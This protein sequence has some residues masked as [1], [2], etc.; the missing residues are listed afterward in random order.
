M[1]SPKDLQRRLGG[2]LFCL[3]LILFFGS[4]F[5]QEPDPAEPEQELK[6]L[7]REAKANPS[8]ADPEIL[9]EIYLD[10][11]RHWPRQSDGEEAVRKV[12]EGGE[13][14]IPHLMRLLD[15]RDYRLKPAVA[16]ILSRFTLSDEDRETARA[17]IEPLLFH[18]K[19]KACYRHLLQ[20][21]HAI[22]R[23]HAE[24]LSV[25][26]LDSTD[27]AL[28]QAAFAVL[29]ESTSAA[30][31]DALRTLLVVAEGDTR[32][33]AFQLM[34][35]NPD[36]CVDGA[37]LA[38]VGDEHAALAADVT[39]YL[40]HRNNEQVKGELKTMLSYEPDRVFA[41]AVAAMVSL[42]NNYNTV[43]LTEEQIPSLERFLNARDPLLRVIAAIALGNICSR[44]GQESDRNRLRN[45]VVPTLMDVFL[46][47][48]Y[49]KDFNCM[50]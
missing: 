20:A 35:K 38:L 2:S 42:E 49:F 14:M 24:S 37:A 36:A 12:I 33:K 7:K 29:N 32:H 48:R 44:S 1:T 30:P 17:K 13:A 6:R 34:S 40:G 43:L 11:F 28:R 31:L 8:V 23:G 4:L 45:Q 26:L 46:K 21:L 3:F 15:H 47:N 16:Y 27:S 18:P 5:A 50:L 9:I 39:A 19:L 10:D 22:D 41:F 25:E